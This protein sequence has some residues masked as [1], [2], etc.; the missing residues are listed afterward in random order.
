M[1]SDVSEEHTAPI[2]KVSQSVFGIM[3]DWL[4]GGAHSGTMAWP[5]INTAARACSIA[6]S[7]LFYFVYFTNI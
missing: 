7:V 4:L 6:N 1:V 2:F 3:L 5:F